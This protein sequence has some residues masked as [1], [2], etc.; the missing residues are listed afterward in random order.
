LRNVEIL[1]VSHGGCLAYCR[2][3]PIT[4]VRNGQ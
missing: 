2:F 3:Q 4:M 1:A